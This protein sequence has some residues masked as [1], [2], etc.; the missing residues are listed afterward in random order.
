[1]TSYFSRKVIQ[2]FTARGSRRLELTVG[3]GFPMEWESYKNPKRMEI[4]DKLGM[5]RNGKQ[6]VWE[7]D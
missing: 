1:V 5:E 2:Y 7:W 6:P 3:I 4:S